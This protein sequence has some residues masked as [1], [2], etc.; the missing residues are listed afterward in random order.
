[1]TE[2]PLKEALNESILDSSWR[3]VPDAA[4]TPASMQAYIH[5]GVS[6]N[7]RGSED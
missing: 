5:A 4:L 1:M 2:C 7:D 6:I 3:L